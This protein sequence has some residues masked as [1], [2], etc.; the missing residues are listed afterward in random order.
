MYFFRPIPNSGVYRSP[1]CLRRQLCVGCAAALWLV[2]AFAQPVGAEDAPAD[3]I[4]ASGA[5][6]PARD[7]GAPPAH[8]YFPSGDST[9][10][11]ETF[12]YP[13]HIGSFPEDIWEGRSGW[14]YA[15]TQKRNVYYKIAK[16][17]DNYYLTAQTEGEAVN[18][19]REAKINLRLYQKL[20]WR[21]RVHNLP[22]GGDETDSEKNDVAASVRIIIGTNPLSARAIKYTWSTT[23]EPRTKTADGQITLGT[24]IDDSRLK[25][26]VLQSGPEKLGKWMWE[27]VDVYED[28]RRLFGGDPRP[29]D[30]LS[31]LTDS[32]NTKTFVKA[33]YDDLIFIIPRPDTVEMIPDFLLQNP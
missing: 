33:D 13:D 22:E 32:D 4:S 27:E 11:L 18:F 30:V 29:M 6:S 7:P 21:W 3:S 5:T 9:F 12:D 24:E 23:L 28:Y 19:G 1:L 25:V 16:E 8:W 2:L 10:A 20:R 31:L 17:N 26:I 14:R 15:K